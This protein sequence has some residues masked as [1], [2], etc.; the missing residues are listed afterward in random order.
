[1]RE[2]KVA[3]LALTEP[4]VRWLAAE[5]GEAGEVEVATPFQGPL[6]LVRAPVAVAWRPEDRRL[7]AAWNVAQ[8]RVLELGGPLD[9]GGFGG[10]RAGRWGGRK[11]EVANEA[12]RGRRAGCGATKSRSQAGDS[13]GHRL[14]GR[15][16]GP[17]GGFA[18]MAGAAGVARGGGGNHRANGEEAARVVA[19][20]RVGG[21]QGGR[22]CRIL[23]TTRR[24]RCGRK[25]GRLG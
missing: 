23:I 11:R 18:G 8:A 22:L 14:C 2:G 20:Q 10:A 19:C 24:R 25:P 17:G 13:R 9:L 16:G 6:E 21:G 5:A 15:G 4:A 7:R 12:A 3:G 1:L